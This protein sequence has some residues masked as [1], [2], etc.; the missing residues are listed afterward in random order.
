[1]SLLKDLDPLAIAALSYIRQR[2]MPSGWTEENYPNKWPFSVVDIIHSND[3]SSFDQ[4]EINSIQ[5]L[6]VSPNPSNGRFVVS[7]NL[8]SSSAIALRILN[9]STGRLEFSQRYG[10]D[11]NFTIPINLVLAA[12]MYVLLVETEFGATAVYKII[13]L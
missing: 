1:M 8:Q 12:D 10:P 3:F 5:N 11:K 4:G 7:L 6:N 2:N 13:I 9:V